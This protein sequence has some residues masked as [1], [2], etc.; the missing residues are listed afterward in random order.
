MSIAYVN[1]TLYVKNESLNHLVAERDYAAVKAIAVPA[2]LTAASYYIPFF[3]TAVLGYKTINSALDTVNDY[4]AG[5]SYSTLALDAVK[6]AAWATAT[7]I[8]TTTMDFKGIKASIKSYFPSKDAAPVHS[9]HV[10]ANS[11]TLKDALSA[12]KDIAEDKM[13]EILTTV[14]NFKVVTQ[15]IK[16][17]I[18]FHHMPTAWNDVAY[19]TFPATVVGADSVYNHALEVSAYN[20]A[21]EELATTGAH[22][23]TV[24]AGF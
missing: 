15:E 10:V 22:T 17:N 2:V 4:K 14:D 7:A 11:N 16:S 6:T 19:A 9:E 24:D 18:E 21:I 13:S 5:A 1:N 23:V 3:G 12:I 8:S 20:E